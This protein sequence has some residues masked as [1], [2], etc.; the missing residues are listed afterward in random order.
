MS[1]ATCWKWCLC[2]LAIPLACASRGLG[3]DPDIRA[4]FLSAYSK[5]YGKLVQNYTNIEYRYHS[6]A[7]QGKKLVQ[8]TSLE[9]KFNLHHYLGRYE[10]RVARSDT[11][12]TTLELRPLIVAANTKYTFE[13]ADYGEKYVVR[14]LEMLPPNGRADFMPFMAPIADCMTNRTYLEIAED[15]ETGFISMVDTKFRG[16]NVKQLTLGVPYFN[17][18]TKKNT[19]S[20]KSYFFLPE[21][22]WLC[23]G[24]TQDIEPGSKYI[25]E[26]YEYEAEGAYPP[27][28]LIERTFRDRQ[29]PTTSELA[30]RIE[31]TKFTRVAPLDEAEF[32]L[33]AFG[34]PEPLGVTWSKPTRWYL[35]LSLAGALCLGGSGV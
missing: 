4:S 28:K 35:W 31:F 13:L 33:S 6:E 32:R 3:A 7:P 22:G 34:L 1:R 26:S 19:R 20:K 12:E 11:R 18:I 29:D 9:G 2:A 27:L 15:P 5:A 17:I 25:E 16:L 10:G 8:L 23:L 30:W 24:W 14:K 21:R